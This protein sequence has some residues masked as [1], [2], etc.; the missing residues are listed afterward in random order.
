[1]V[2]SLN[3]MVTDGSRE[4]AINKFVVYMYNGVRLKY[5]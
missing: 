2:A 1:M 5:D 3:I 4:K